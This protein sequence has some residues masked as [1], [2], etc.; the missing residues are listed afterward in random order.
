MANNLRGAAPVVAVRSVAFVDLILV[1][2]RTFSDGG[3]RATISS[4]I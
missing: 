3:A 4:V 2:V 1:M